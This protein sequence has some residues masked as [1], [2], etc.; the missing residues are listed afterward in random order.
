MRC[1]ASGGTVVDRPSRR[2]LSGP[3]M[4]NTRVLAF[5]GLLL[6]SACPK[7][8]EP[9]RATIQRAFRLLAAATERETIQFPDVRGDLEIDTRD[10]ERA[11]R[12]VA[13]GQSPLFALEGARA[14]LAGD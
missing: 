1:S 7:R 6:L 9:K 5:V 3:A 13:T 8:V 2:S 14:R 10:H 12:V 11:P 4:F